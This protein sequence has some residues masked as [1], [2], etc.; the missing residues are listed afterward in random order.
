MDIHHKPIAQRIEWLM[1]RALRHSEAFSS[2]EAFLARQRY[3]A[4]HPSAVAAFKCMDGRIN[5]SVATH[6]PLGIIQPF[7]NLGGMFNLGWPHLGEVL[8]NYVHDQVST[9]RQVLLLIT[10][11][12]SKSDKQR[13]CAGFNYDTDAARAH[14]YA[15]KLQIE[16]VF[17]AVHGTVYPIVCGFETDEDALVL[18]GTNG[19][20]LDLSQLAAHDR[21]GLRPRLEQI[22][23]D[24]PS[25]IRHDLE[26]L[27]L[28]NMDRIVEVRNMERTLDVEHRE[29]MICVGRGF[30]FLHM[31]N[32]ALIIGPY[33]PDLAEP[34]DQA[35]GI[36]D[37]NMRAGRIPDDGFLLLASVPYAEV[38]VDRARAELKSRFLSRF[39]AD[40]IR[41][42]HP[43]LAAKMQ[44]RTAVLDWRSRALGTIAADE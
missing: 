7:R 38:G 42:K 9:G 20:M 4:Q 31:P 35:A 21:D 29:W 17:G 10:Y 16:H 41:A 27:V 15:I 13:G 11:H 28:G 14:T 32:L 40:V 33:S 12:Y 5:L 37:A 25:Q 19:D 18:H 3:M 1:G 44:V 26:P 6:T 30:D 24:M 34:I 22:F 43:A 23:P 2:S 36:I 8:A 39:A